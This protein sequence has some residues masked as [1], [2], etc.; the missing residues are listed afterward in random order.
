MRNIV[1]IFLV[2]FLWFPNKSFGQ[3]GHLF[4]SI[5]ETSTVNSD[6]VFRI[7]LSKSKLISF[8]TQILEFKNLKE[9]Y[10]SK[11]KIKTLPSDLMNLKNLEVLDLSKN[12]FSTFPA[13]LCNVNSLKQL[14]LGRNSIAVIPECIGQLENLQVLDIW[15]NPIDGLPKSITNLKKLTDLDLR[16]INM[17]HKTQAFI[18]ALLPWTK[19]EFDAGCDCGG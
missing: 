18:K 16:G 2:L 17:S 13:V 8:P 7:D 4:T 1:V 10:L 5:E 3:T 14:F 6:S 15:F 9:L 19:I 12:D 11:N